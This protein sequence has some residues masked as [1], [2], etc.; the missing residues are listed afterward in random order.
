MLRKN[1]GLPCET[2]LVDKKFNYFDGCVFIPHV[3]IAAKP[4]LDIVGGW[5]R[6]LGTEPGNAR[7]EAATS[8]RTSAAHPIPEGVSGVQ[9]S[10]SI[11]KP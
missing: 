5:L 2:N 10:R 1:S 6:K 4:H 8:L 11:R 7:Q 9:R 3:L